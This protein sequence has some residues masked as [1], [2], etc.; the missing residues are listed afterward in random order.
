VAVEP[1]WACWCSALTLS[2]NGAPAVPLSGRVRSPLARALAVLMR[3]EMKAAMPCSEVM[4]TRRST[5]GVTRTHP[6]ER[7]RRVARVG[8]Y[9]GS[10]CLPLNDRKAGTGRHFADMKSF[11][12]R[13]DG[14]SLR[15]RVLLL[16]PTTHRSVRVSGS[17]LVEA[18]AVRRLLALPCELSRCCASCDVAEADCLAARISLIAR[19]HACGALFSYFAR[20]A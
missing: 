2:L 11:P 10:G 7:R 16:L 9:T 18:A 5:A 17:K 13:C 6:R 1:G 8:A 14:R 19:R 20:V 12:V 15:C 3:G 4:T